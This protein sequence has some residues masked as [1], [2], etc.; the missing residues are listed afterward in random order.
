LGIRPASFT[1]LTL[2]MPA[3]TPPMHGRPF[4]RRI[5]YGA[6]CYRNPFAELPAFSVSLL[7]PLHSREDGGL[8]LFSSQRA[9]QHVVTQSL[10]DGR[11]E[12]YPLTV[13]RCLHLTHWQAIRHLTGRSGLFPSRRGTL[14]HPRLTRLTARRICPI[15]RPRIALSQRFAYLDVRI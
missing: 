10:R 12:T 1:R 7:A 11:F 9:R 15:Q 5:A 4:D 2:L 6:F 3:L 13:T 14:A 8:R